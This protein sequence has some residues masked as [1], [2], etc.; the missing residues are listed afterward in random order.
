MHRKRDILSSYMWDFVG[1]EE[2]VPWH[3]SLC[4]FSGLNTMGLVFYSM[5][6]LRN[7]YLA[8]GDFQYGGET[9]RK[10]YIIYIITIYVYV[11]LVCKAITYRI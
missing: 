10:T 11:S 3:L 5:I 1:K 6:L 9:H 7:C 4:I 8:I 2:T